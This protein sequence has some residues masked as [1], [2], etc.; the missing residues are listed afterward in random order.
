MFACAWNKEFCPGMLD[1]SEK[2]EEPIQETAAMSSAKTSLRHQLY[3][4]P[5]LEQ[6]CYSSPLM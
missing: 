1:C 2:L 5:P 6:K 3:H 4:M